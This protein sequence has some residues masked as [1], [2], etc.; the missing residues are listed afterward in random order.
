MVESDKVRARLGRPKRRSASRQYPLWRSD[1]ASRHARCTEGSSDTVTEVAAKLRSAIG[2]L[3]IV[4][5][6]KG[7][8]SSFFRL[9][10]K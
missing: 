3:D 7:E 1:S 6:T 10:C 2:L 4:R 5:D 9:F 8:E